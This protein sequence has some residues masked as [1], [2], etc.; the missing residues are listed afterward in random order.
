MI[1]Q[2]FIP[3]VFAVLFYSCIATAGPEV[4]FVPDNSIM[5]VRVNAK[6]LWGSDYGKAMLDLMK[7]AGPKAMEEMKARFVPDPTTV[8]SATLFYILPAQPGREPDFAVLVH[9]GKAVGEKEFFKSIPEGEVVKSGNGNMLVVNGLAFRLLSEGKVIAGGAPELVMKLGTNLP[10]AKGDLE[11]Y[12]KTEPVE[13]VSLMVNYTIAPK[14]I[15]QFAPPPF[16]PLISGLKNLQAG[17]TMEKSMHVKLQVMY[18]NETQAK[19]SLDAIKTFAN[20]GLAQV[21]QQ[22]KEFEKMVFSKKE[23]SLPSWMDFPE[24]MAGV[25]G[26]GFSNEVE[27]L[28]K[29]PPIQANGTKLTMNYNTPEISNNMAVPVLVSLL[30]PAVQNARGAAQRMSSVNNLKM[31]G[32]AMHNY[33]ATYNTGFPPVA[34]SDKKTGKPLL[35]WRVAL[36]PY[37]EEDN[38]YRQFKLD[39]PWDS[40][41]NIKLAAKM[42]KVYTHPT[43]NKPGDNKT[44]YRVFYGNGAVFDMN[45]PCS[46]RDITDGT[47]NTVLTVE[48]EAPVFWTKPEE[49]PF[50]PKMDLPKL[51]IINGRTN[52][53]FC[54]GSVRSISGGIKP[55]TLKLLIQR[56]D[57]TPIPPL[58]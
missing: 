23:G 1:L 39:E 46:F 13:T 31:I 37:L 34:I 12:L 32:L 43:K 5:V 2:R 35:S 45:K 53:G 58:D 55:E 42:P 22:R 38:L 11:T 17:F 27:S 3:A 9:L 33:E 8:E 56:N 19:G 47:S 50:D 26:L 41:H 15:G 49:L 6:K 28:L 14:E 40:E 20:M 29:N 36:L 4:A 24:F 30:L 57:G 10:A 51:L 48:S 18:E 54:D 21:Q 44:H 52:M 7:K 25:M 16:L